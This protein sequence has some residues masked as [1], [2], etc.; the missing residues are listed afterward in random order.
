MYVRSKLSLC[1]NKVNCK[2]FTTNN[3]WEMEVILHW[4]THSDPMQNHT[5]LHELRVLKFNSRSDMIIHHNQ[6]FFYW[7]SAGNHPNSAKSCHV[8]HCVTNLTTAY[9]WIMIRLWRGNQRVLREAW[10]KPPKYR[11]TIPC[12]TK[13]LAGTTCELYA[14]TPGRH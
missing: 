10:E 4:V 12:S 3:K 9:A 11:L 13:T 7:N 2:D 8:L 1:H 5:H 14:I 6:L